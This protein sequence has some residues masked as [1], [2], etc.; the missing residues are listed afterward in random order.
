[1]AIYGYAGK[2][3]YVDLS[4]RTI[5]KETLSEE[6]IRGYIGSLGINSKLAYDLIEPGADPLSPKNCIVLGT[7]PLGGTTAP[8]CSRSDGNCK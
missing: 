2:I 6:L 1:M 4:S 5:K 8:A 7:R 3:L